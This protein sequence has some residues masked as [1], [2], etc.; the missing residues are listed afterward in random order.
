M[1][2]EYLCTHHTGVAQVSAGLASVCEHMYACARTRAHAFWS[3]D[4][5]PRG[6]EI[7]TLKGEVACQS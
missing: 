4:Y 6:A 2:P 3:Y 1:A 5:S 7:R